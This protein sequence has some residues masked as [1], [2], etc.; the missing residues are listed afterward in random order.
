MAF[1]SLVHASGNRYHLA[2]AEGHDG[3][4]VVFTRGEIPALGEPV[5]VHINADT[6]LRR[7][8][9]NHR[10]RTKLVLRVKRYAGELRP[11]QARAVAMILT[12]AKS[13]KR[14]NM[15][16]KYIT[17]MNE[18]VTIQKSSTKGY[19]IEGIFLQAA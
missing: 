5:I 8:F 2:A 7:G 4:V 14:T 11:E 3:P 18:N 1:E 15:G 17:E 13:S 16:M 12:S 6:C 9:G 19:F 10:H